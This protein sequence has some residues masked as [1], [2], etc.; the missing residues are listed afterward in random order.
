M[1]PGK[2]NPIINVAYHEAHQMTSDQ[3]SERT[4]ASSWLIF[5]HFRQIYNLQNRAV[6]TLRCGRGYTLTEDKRIAVEW[7]ITG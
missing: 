3:E 1:S 5:D 2:G 7:K 4:A 6:T